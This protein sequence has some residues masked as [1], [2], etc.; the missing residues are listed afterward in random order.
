M[1]G[2]LVK[3][4]GIPAGDHFGRGGGAVS[5][6]LSSDGRWIIVTDT[7]LVCGIVLVFQE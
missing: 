6:E 3:V 4:D 1:P 5:A 2:K 7:R